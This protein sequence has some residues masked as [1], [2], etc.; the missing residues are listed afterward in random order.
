MKNLNNLLSFLDRSPTSFHAAKNLIQ[1]SGATLFEGKVESKKLY[2]L[3]KEGSVFFFRSPLKIPKKAV[4]CAAHTDSPALKLKPQPEVVRDNLFLLASDIY[5]CPLL[6]SWLNRDLVIAGK[7]A[8]ENKGKIEERLVHLEDHPL[9]I[10]QLAPHLDHGVNE[11]G[12]ILN[13][14]D[15]LNALAGYFNP[16]LEGRLLQTLL[17]VKNLISHDLFLVPK[18]KASLIG[19]E[20]SFIASYRLDNLSSCYAILEALKKSS[21]HTL[22]IAIFWDHE[23]IGSETHSGALSP[24]FLDSLER[25]AIAHDLDRLAFLD[26]KNNSKT[27]S[28]DLAHAKNPNYPEKMDPLHAP[29]LG[30]GPVVKWSASQRYATSC[31]SSSSLPSLQRFIIRSNLK[32]GSTIGPLHATLTGIPTTDLGIPQLS[33]HSIR[34]IIATKDYQAL[35]ALLKKLYED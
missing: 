1:Q 17:N 26:L 33:M 19:Y 34:E 23:E 20:N 10:P 14:Q 27:Y 8:F 18:E 13:K 29:L 28:I 32:G 21:P 31:T 2:Y 12:P 7:I 35:L 4:I 25:I 6:T 11:M 22:A 3:E 15:H 24:F 9:T 16:K 5:G 30:L